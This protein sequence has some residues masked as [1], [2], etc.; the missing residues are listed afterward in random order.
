V[1]STVLWS[2]PTV[3]RRC[4]CR[5]HMQARADNVTLNQDQYQQRVQERAEQLRADHNCPHYWQYRKPPVAEYCGHCHSFPLLP[6]LLLLSILSAGG[7]QH[8]Q[9]SQ[10]TVGLSQLCYVLHLCCMLC[11]GICLT[12]LGCNQ[13]VRTCLSCWLVCTDSLATRHHR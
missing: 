5:L 1:A 13:G 7:L 2:D 9:V 10:D 3:L 11:V 8:M 6:L 12:C 4:R